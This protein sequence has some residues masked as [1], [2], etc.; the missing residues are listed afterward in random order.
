M[1]RGRLNLCLTGI[2]VAILLVLF[3][4]SKTSLSRAQ[5]GTTPIGHEGIWGWDWMQASFTDY[6][7][8]G[9]DNGW[10]QLNRRWHVRNGRYVLDGNY[11]PDAVGRG[12]MSVTH[13]GDA[14]WRDYM[15]E[16]TFDM[17]NPSGLP[18]PDVHDAQFFFRVQTPPP[19][20]TF[21]RLEVFAKG[22]GDP[23]G[24]GEILKKGLVQLWRFEDG[25][26]VTYVF[27]E[28][29]NSVIG[30]NHIH[31]LVHEKTI[32][33]WINGEQVLKTTDDDALAYGGVG[34]GAAWESQAW[35]DNVLVIPVK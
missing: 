10:T 12:G 15:L 20:G 29:S 6:F 5:S 4:T 30:S 14:T 33:V 28:N 13:V 9:N 22:A 1:H 23:R 21:Y 35:F 31:I 26:P 19:D 3:T 8:D 7:N 34:L 32:R 24:S 2:A 17:Q 16:A 27:A 18:S 25:S 11:L